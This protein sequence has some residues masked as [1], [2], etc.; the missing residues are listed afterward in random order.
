MKRSTP[1]AGDFPPAVRQKQET[2]ASL[3]VDQEREK[4]HNQTAHPLQTTGSDLGTSL[5]DQQL[6]RKIIEEFRS[7][8]SDP[9]PS[10]NQ[11]LPL[12]PLIAK[13]SGNTLECRFDVLLDYIAD[14]NSI[15]TVED[16]W[17]TQSLG[18]LRTMPG[19]ISSLSPICLLI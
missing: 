9:H 3:L 7:K 13:H 5:T 15:P 1:P 4:I 19:V 14:P 8:C 11:L 2:P 16:A 18:R 6:D 17:K 10:G 12:F